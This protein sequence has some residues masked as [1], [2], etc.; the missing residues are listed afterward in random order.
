MIDRLKTIVI[1]GL[2]TGLIWLY[3]EA[4]SLTS[5]QEDARVTLVSPGQDV[6]VR[7]A[8]DEWHGAVR[9]T[10]EG[11]TSALAR[12]PRTFTL[13]PGA[14]GFALADGEQAVDLRTALR[15]DPQLA[16]A[17]VTLIDVEP[18]TV[19]LRVTT[20]ARMADVEVRADLSG[21]ELSAPATVEPQRVV[22]VAPRA[23]LDRLRALNGGAA[24]VAKPAAAALLQVREGVRQ[25]VQARLS[26]P[27]EIDDAD[28]MIE[29]GEASITLTARSRTESV[30]LDAVQVQVMMP[31]GEATRYR[32]D[33]APDEQ[34]VANVTITGP[35][36][37][38]ERVRSGELRLIAVVSLSADDLTR[39][40][41][42]K[43]LSFVAMRGEEPAAL[44]PGVAFT[45]GQNAVR[46]QIRP[47][48]APIPAP[49]GPR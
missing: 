38:V 13:S 1:V 28:A 26:F 43:R 31:P 17:G 42:V 24:V 18:S 30:T 7:A 4:E 48:L 44:P 14:P 39:R 20:L 36:D 25:R 23:T 5:V 27:A 15:V 46:L 40:V 47:L 11:P 12:A 29:P 16:R 2:A 35:R 3:A 34:T 33:V 49:N 32:I 22:V 21:V 8:S 6:V 45:A 37:V 19:R 10:L 9:V 41:E